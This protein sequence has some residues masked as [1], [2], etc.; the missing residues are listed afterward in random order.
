MNEQISHLQ[1]ASTCFIITG[2]CYLT[3]GF[4]FWFLGA[5]DESGS[6]KVI[7]P[8]LVVLEHVIPPNLQGWAGLIGTVSML[9][10]VVSLWKTG[11]PTGSGKWKK[12]F[13]VSIAGAVF[14]VLGQWMPL[15]FA[16]LG[17]L[18]SG[19]G[20]ILI[21]IASIKTK[22]WTGWQRYMPLVVGCFP[23]LFMFPLLIIT[24][25][26]PAAV[27]GF[28]GLPWIALGLAAWQR[29]QSLKIL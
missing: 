8:F 3:F 15:P 12:A 20:M 14:Y 7:L 6:A 11:E 25:N 2:L 13:G 26:R 4:P 9:I 17:A 23:F 22:I 24:G 10:G 1:R 21:G 28:W 27:I 29:V 5:V 19:L 18:F 16:P